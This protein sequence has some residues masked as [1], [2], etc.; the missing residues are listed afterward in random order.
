MAVAEEHSWLLDRIF[1]EF[2]NFLCKNLRQSAVVYELI[3]H[4]RFV[5]LVQACEAPDSVAECLLRHAC[6]LHP[7]L[8]CASHANRIGTS[9]SCNDLAYRVSA[10]HARRAARHFEQFSWKV[11][12]ARALAQPVASRSAALTRAQPIH[13]VIRETHRNRSSA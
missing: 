12:Q 13:V 6:S 2:G 10:L 3:S 7:Q 9:K 11:V 5:G 1:L 8:G 4:P